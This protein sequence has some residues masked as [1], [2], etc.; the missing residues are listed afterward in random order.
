M[1][2]S[3][4]ICQRAAPTDGAPAR[5]KPVPVKLFHS[6][7]NPGGTSGGEQRDGT[8]RWPRRSDDNCT[9]GSAIFRI[10][11]STLVLS[12]LIILPSNPGSA[13]SITA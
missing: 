11:V 10:N 7:M 5:P 12:V 6:L 4:P 3:S 8:L 2:A 13:G 9:L 1:A